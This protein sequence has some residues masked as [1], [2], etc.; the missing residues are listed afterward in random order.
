MG[1]DVDIDKLQF[2]Q[3]C[4]YYHKGITKYS[5]TW[6]I[7]EFWISP[8]IL[9]MDGRHDYTYEK[10]GVGQVKPA[11]AVNGISTINASHRSTFPHMARDDPLWKG[12]KYAKSVSIGDTMTAIDQH[13]IKNNCADSWCCFH[14]FP[15]FLVELK[16]TQVKRTKRIGHDFDRRQT[17]ESNAWQKSI[18]NT[19][20]AHMAGFHFAADCLFES[21]NA[22][23]PVTSRTSLFHAFAAKSE[24]NPNRFHA[25]GYGSMHHF[26]E[27]LSS[28]GLDTD[29]NWTV[30]EYVKSYAS[31][32]ERQ[33]HQ[34]GTLQ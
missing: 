22:S 14:M 2:Y 23:L 12:S 24:C 26:L 15:S 4:L 10:L 32:V 13:Y 25:Q 8:K 6:D 34:S 5:A 28:R 16:D 31:T 9:H 29:K 11:K 21:M 3:T 20:Y 7:N 19:K 18:A 1:C 33:L 30:D 17:Q 27:L